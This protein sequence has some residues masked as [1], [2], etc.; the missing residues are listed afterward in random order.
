MV[1]CSPSTPGFIPG[2]HQKEIKNKVKEGEKTMLAEEN[3]LTI[4]SGLA[5]HF[6]SFDLSS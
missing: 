5:F 1:D 3:I 2:T 6:L 4:V